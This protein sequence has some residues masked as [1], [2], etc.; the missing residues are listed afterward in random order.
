MNTNITADRRLLRF[1]FPTLAAR[2]VSFKTSFTL[3]LSWFIHATRRRLSHSLKEC[4]R[5]VGAEWVCL[6]GVRLEEF[7]STELWDL[8]E[9]LP[10]LNTMS[11]TIEKNEYPKASSKCGWKWVCSEGGNLNLLHPSTW[12]HKLV[13]LL[14][15]AADEPARWYTPSGTVKTGWV[16]TLSRKCL[17]S[18]SDALVLGAI[19]SYVASIFLMMSF[20]SPYWIESYS[21]SF[22]SF[23][24]M[25]LWEYCFKDFT[26]P[27][28]QYPR[29]FNGCHHIFSEVCLVSS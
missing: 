26:Y 1:N 5:V 18:I 29:L 28:Y 25:G 6:I 8:I 9:R 22:S 2:S 20:C 4:R 10:C 3:L 17:W 7:W 12:R 16:W 15:L 13:V 11:S 21:E 19:L 14:L 24:N 27:Y 23:K